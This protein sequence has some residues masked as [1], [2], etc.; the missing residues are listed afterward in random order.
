MTDSFFF[1]LLFLVLLLLTA[2]FFLLKKIFELSKE[3]KEMTFTKTSQSIKYGQLTEQ[4]IPFTKD[5]PFSPK[6]FRFLGQPIDGIVFEEDK[7]IF[8]EFKTNT[9]QLNPKQKKIRELVKEKKV[10]WLEFRVN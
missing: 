5:F 2:V 8:C 6:D 7:I 4:W 3:L 10:N 1:A 9:A